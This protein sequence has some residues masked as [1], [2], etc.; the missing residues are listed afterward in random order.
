MKK[1]TAALLMAMFLP[2]MAMANTYQMADN[3]MFKDVKTVKVTFSG[4][5]TIKK[6]AAFM[7]VLDEI[8][9][10][11]VNAEHVY[12]YFN[13]VGG[14]MDSALS[15]Y[16]AIRGSRLP[17][18]TVNLSVVASAATIPYCAADQ[19][20]SMKEAIFIIHP[21]QMGS[22]DDKNVTPSKIRITENYISNYNTLFMNI[23]SHCTDFSAQQLKEPLYSDD[24]RLYLSAAQ[25][26]QHR[27]STQIVD[28][29]TA[30]PVSYFVTDD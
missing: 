1:K 19:R 21:A 11:Y 17:V 30:A 27:M 22:L 6:S 9:Q 15:M 28:K 5:I 29:M 13:S 20:Q 16:Y 4:L 25:S 23:Y 7:S 18:T 2:F 8:N 12:L 26:V 24:S 10:R 3:T 14:D